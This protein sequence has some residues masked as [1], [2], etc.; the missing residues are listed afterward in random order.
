M[1]KPRNVILSL[2]VLLFLVMPAFADNDNAGCKSGHFVGS[3][4]AVFSNQDV[5]GNGTVIHT[6]I[7]QLNLH[8]DGIAELNNTANLEYP[9]NAGSQGPWIGSWQCRSDGKLVV[10]LLRSFYNPVGPTPNTTYADIELGGYNRFT[11]LFSVEDKDTVKR[12]ARRIRRYGANEDP[13]DPSGGTL[14]PLE[15]NEVVFKRL[16]ASGADLLAP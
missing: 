14:F 15:T 5:F 12:V 6:W 1:S 9:I 11:Y 3:Y 10:T 16:N 2:A 4:N 7:E 13:T 8:S